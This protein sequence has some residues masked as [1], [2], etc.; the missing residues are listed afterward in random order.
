MAS[1]SRIGCNRLDLLARWLA[2]MLSSPARSS[3]VTINCCI[4]QGSH[5][6][7]LV[8]EILLFIQNRRPDRPPLSCMCTICQLR[9]C[10]MQFTPL[11]DSSSAH[12]HTATGDR[13]LIETS[14]PRYPFHR[15]RAFT[16]FRLSILPKN[17]L[18][19]NWRFERVP[20]TL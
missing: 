4:P 17:D 7:F 3:H 1:R 18:Y 12:C 11:P 9:C 8:T 5:R 13:E 6:V 20:R 16:F 14:E 10:N 2:C 19:R 15:I